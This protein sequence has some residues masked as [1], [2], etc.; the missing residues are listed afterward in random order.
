MSNRI[1]NP[2][3]V[4]RTEE[5]RALRKMLPGSSG[6]SG[7]F[8]AIAGEPGIGKT[9]LMTEIARIAT[10]EGKR[11]LWSQ[12]VEDFA[13]PPFFCWTLVLRD[14]VQQFD[15]DVIRADIGSGAPDIADILPELCHRFGIEVDPIGLSRSGGHYALFDAVTRHLLT[16]ARRDP[17]IVLLDNLHSADR[18]SLMLLEYLCQQIAGSPILVIGAYRHADFDRRNPLRFVLAKLSRTPGFQQISLRGL[19]LD[20][21]ALVLSTHVGSPIPASLV[22][23]I[24]ERSDGSPLFVG[25][26]ARMLAEPDSQRGAYQPN[27]LVHVPASLRDVINVRL[28]AL[29]AETL[30]I[31]GIAA[32]LGRDFDVSV[33]AELAELPGELVNI[34]L[35]QA[36]E[37]G[38]IRA[39]HLGRYSFRHV[40]FREVLYIEHSTVAR[41]RL[42]RRTG[43]LLESRH[44]NGGAAHYTELAHHFFESAQL[45][46]GEKALLYCRAAADEAAKRRAYAEAVAMYE[47]ALQVVE[48]QQESNSETRFDLLFRVGQS[49][50]SSGELNAATQSL[51][52]SAILAYRERWWFR[53]ADAL[54]VYQLVCQQSGFRHIAS[55]PLHELVLEHIP[56]ESHE[57]RARTLVSLAKAYRTAGRPD[58]AGSVFQSGV[59][60]ARRCDDSRVLFDCLRKGNWTVGRHPSSIREGLE[61]S[62]EALA[63]ARLH[64]SA[65]AVIDSLTDIVFQLCDLGEIDEV[66]QRLAEM[67][68]LARQERQRHFL[69]V[70]TGFETSVAI[71]RGNWAEG[72]CKAQETLRQIPVQGVLGLE[73]RYAFQVFSIKRAQGQLEEMREIA[74]AILATSAITNFWLPGQIM[75]HCELEQYARARDALR[76]L[77][78]LRKLPRDDLYVTS[79]I[80]LAESCV[81]LRDKARCSQIYELLMPY[82]SLNATLPGTLMQGAVSGYLGSLAVTTRNAMEASVLFEE[83]IAMNTAMRAL[84]FLA[85]SQVDYARVLFASDDHEAHIRARQLVTA[86]L[87]VANELNLRPLQKAITALQETSAIDSLTGR[88][89]DILRVVAVGL[90]NKRIADTL[91]I[92]HSTVTTHMRH[93][94]RKT[95]ARNRTEAAE[96]ARRAGLLENS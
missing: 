39:L 22:R 80:Y 28:D 55:I 1:A 93:I 21:V 51:M 79:L 73:G 37:A 17:L 91:H 72:Y 16:V 49:Q 7:R 89:V 8:V 69:N 94:F 53:L 30:K 63:L 62:R 59:E 38:I 82:R 23:S 87:S 44:S 81:V 84:P 86:A 76:Q 18:S 19:T 35:N 50:F 90:S 78:D 36:E 60:L 33:L 57:V 77:G 34:Q 95:G 67:A 29:P 66:E 92:S 70:L 52:K 58:L 12:M 47:R 83:A 96:Y 27:Y 25:E 40:S 74:D 15:D 9:R 65:E 56:D 43:E 14:Y 45:D 46:N 71:L 26:M 42:H 88:E 4:G 13:A 41:V 11:V 2:P 24:H 48:L 6:R 20:E 32:V 61:I 85:R 5:L 68:N 75:L 54:F 10:A 3:F 64:E 31:L